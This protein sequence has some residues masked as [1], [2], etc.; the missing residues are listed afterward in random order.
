MS[1]RKPPKGGFVHTVSFDAFFGS[2]AAAEVAAC[3]VK[4]SEGYSI[5]RARKFTT[6][7]A[8]KK[9]TRRQILVERGRELQKR[10]KRQPRPE[11]PVVERG[12]SS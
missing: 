5:H 6:C 9:V 11:A 2:N 7:P 12:L 1:T 8:C 4:K 3:G 10:A